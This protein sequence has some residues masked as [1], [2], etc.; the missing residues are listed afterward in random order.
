[1]ILCY[2]SHSIKKNNKHDLQVR[3]SK[4]IQ[5][6]SGQNIILNMLQSATSQT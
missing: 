6:T 2:S 3:V 1:M 5:N 4:H